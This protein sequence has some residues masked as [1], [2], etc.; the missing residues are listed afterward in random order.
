MSNQSVSSDYDE[1]HNS[2]FY[3][4][5]GTLIWIAG[6]MRSGKS[7]ELIKHVRRLRVAGKMVLLV[8]HSFDTRNEGD[9]S[10]AETLSETV[11][12]LSPAVKPV[13]N[14]RSIHSRDG[15]LERCH[16]LSRL[17]GVSNPSTLAKYDVLAID[18]AQ[19]FE[20]LN[21]AVLTWLNAGKIVITAGL[22]S[23]FKAEPFRHYTDLVALAT[24]VTKLK[25]VC[26]ICKSMDASFSYRTNRTTNLIEIGDKYYEARCFRCYRQPNILED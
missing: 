7:L 3:N 6:P 16:A 12:L 23:S 19:F 15:L 21:R 13:V 8:K 22:D 20:D 17:G 5:C 4:G 9:D 26:N 14:Y 2:D 1:F 18:E 10:D 11:R 24:D 25:A